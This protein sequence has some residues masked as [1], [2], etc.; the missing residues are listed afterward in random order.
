MSATMDAAEGPA[1]FAVYHCRPGAMIDFPLAS[2]PYVT[3]VHALTRIQSINYPGEFHDGV[4]VQFR[5]KPGFEASEASLLEFLQKSDPS[6]AFIWCG[7]EQVTIQRP[8]APIPWYQPIT[9]K[10]ALFATLVSALGVIDAARNHWLEFFEPA[11]IVGAPSGEV[12]NVLGEDPWKLEF[13]LKNVSRGIECAV[14]VE[15]LEIETPHA[16]TRRI[17]MA[18]QKFPGIKSGSAET[19]KLESSSLSEADATALS[20]NPG[21][22]QV[23]VSGTA[24]G[25][26]LRGSSPFTV[27]RQLR[28]WLP[29][30]KGVPRVLPF[31]GTNSRSAQIQIP[32]LVGKSCPNGHWVR[33]VME[34]CEIKA[35][36]PS[37]TFTS[38][39]KPTYNATGSRAV[40]TVRWETAKVGPYQQY[41]VTI[42]VEAEQ[43]LDRK[44][45]DDLVRNSNLLFR[46]ED[47]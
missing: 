44:G 41:Y 30:S 3:A 42:A 13:Q 23:V 39:P 43:E 9:V 21:T 45:W 6:A 32:I 14:E 12:E 40:S 17:K 33:L 24:W 1:F 38:L 22:Y 18:R 26:Y 34:G 36:R 5:D 20:R 7:V 2:F 11:E 35:A 10:W 16:G 46:Y 25:G 31:S 29:M 4:V 15:R 19:F 37:V 28:I 8:K 27:T 47:K